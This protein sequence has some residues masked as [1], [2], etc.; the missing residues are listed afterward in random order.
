ML[1]KQQGKNQLAFITLSMFGDKILILLHRFKGQT[2]RY[3][4]FIDQLNVL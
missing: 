2:D 1:C 4:L 3:R